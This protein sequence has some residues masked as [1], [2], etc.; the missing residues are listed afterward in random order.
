MVTFDQAYWYTHE[1]PLRKLNKPVY[2]EDAAALSIRKAVHSTLIEYFDKDISNIKSEI[3]DK[4]DI[5]AIK[6]GVN[7]ESMIRR[8]NQLLINF[9]IWKSKHE[10]T[11]VI[12]ESIDTYIKDMKIDIDLVRYKSFNSR[13]Q[14]IWFRYDSLVP[15]LSDFSKLVEQAQWNARGFELSAEAKPMQLTYFFP[16]LGNEYS[17]LYN[18]ENGYDTVAKLIKESIYYTRPSSVCDICDSCPMTWQN[19]KGELK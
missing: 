10:D 15:S 16:I 6:T 7:K 14:L 17:V 11:E 3:I 2:P 19:Y 4:L 12:A 5:K 1:C 9:E 18:I 13:I 8:V